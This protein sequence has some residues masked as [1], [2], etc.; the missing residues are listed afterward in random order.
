MRVM[1]ASEQILVGGLFIRFYARVVVVA[2]QAG[3][4][5]DREQKKKT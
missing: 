3:M 2:V 1:C 5:K 4:H